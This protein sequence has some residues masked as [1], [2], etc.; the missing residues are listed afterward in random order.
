MSDCIDDIIKF[1]Y[2]LDTFQDKSIKCIRKGNN[3]LVTAHT[4][5]GKSTVAEYAIAHAR[6]LGKRILYT[7]PI[8]ALSNQKYNDFQKKF[9]N[10]VGI[11]TGDIKVRPDAEILVA[12]TEIVNNLLY[13]DAS[14]FDDVYAIVLDEVHYIRDEDRGHVWE[15]VITLC[16]KHVILVMLSASIPG[17]EGFAKWVEKIKEKPCELISTQYRPV[18]LIHNVYWNGVMEPIMDNTQHMFEKGYRTILEDWKNYSNMRI[19]DKPTR[20]RLLNDF[21]KDVEKKELFPALFFMFSRKNCEVL[22]KMVQDSYLEGKELTQ[23]INLFEFYVKKYLGESG[24]Q[25]SQVWMIRSLLLKGVCIHHSGLIPVLKEII[26]TLFDKGWIKVM[27]VTETFSVGINMPT[28]CVVFGELS[29]YDGKTKRLINPEEYCQMAGRAG[30]RGKDDK[31]TVIYFPLPPRDMLGYYE[32]HSVLKGTHSKVSSKFQMDP[33]LLLKCFAA[34]KSPYELL[35]NSMMAHET[36]DY[37]KGLKIQNETLLQQNI[38]AEQS[39]HAYIAKNYNNNIKEIKEKFITYTEYQEKLTKN[40]KANAKKKILSNIYKLKNSGLDDEMLKLFNLKKETEKEL[41]KNI[42]NSNEASDYIKDTLIWQI[43]V[44]KHHG[45]LHFNTNELETSY[46]SFVASET[47]MLPPEAVSLKG[48]IASGINESDSFLTS[49]FMIHLSEYPCDENVWSAFIGTLIH[50]KSF[51]DTYNEPLEVLSNVMKDNE[52]ESFMIIYNKIKELHDLLDKEQRLRDPDY[53]LCPAFACYTYLWNMGKKYS[54]IQNI[55][56]WELYEG[57]F[58]RNML[59]TYNILEELQN[60]A[61]ILQ[62]SDHLIM[63]NNIRT[64]IIRDI[65]LNDSLYVS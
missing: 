7:S 13:L 50:D 18:P 3:V 58:V 16:P 63:F 8:K 62:L 36:T 59:K 34:E 22:A 20:S 45:Y 29:K 33:V 9:G 31:G 46:K 43:D 1:P 12:T 11:M 23:S 15:E 28:K 47:K 64:K 30:R 39:I 17:A 49:E 4:S 56:S 35:E 24:M 53:K 5:A 26:E 51:D 38:N 6:Y 61:E 14:Y 41:S 40:P 37:I 44:L 19:K 42:K 65:V 27:F 55:L 25:L 48:R 32:I 21:V 60:A 54:D 52:F 2:K 10:H 57:N